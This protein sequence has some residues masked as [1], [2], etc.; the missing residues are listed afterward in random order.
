MENEIEYFTT[1][2]SKYLF[3][4]KKTSAV[5]MCILMSKMLYATSEIL[6]QEQLTVPAGCDESTIN[7][8]TCVKLNLKIIYP[9]FSK[10]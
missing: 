10:D 6:P 4:E 1:E 3:K 7:T 2:T 9:N 5:M 8:I